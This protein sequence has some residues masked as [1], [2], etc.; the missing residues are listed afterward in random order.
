MIT[1]ID[2]ENGL[3][4]FADVQGTLPTDLIVFIFITKDFTD[5]LIKKWEESPRRNFTLKEY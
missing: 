1:L 4:K 2:Y 3:Q 5:Q